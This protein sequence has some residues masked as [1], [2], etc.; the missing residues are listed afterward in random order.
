[1][2]VAETLRS[3]LI[4]QYPLDMLHAASGSGSMAFRWHSHLKALS[5]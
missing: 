4:F 3:N 5:C 1:M 2:I